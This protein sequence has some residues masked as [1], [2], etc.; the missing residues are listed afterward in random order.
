MNE[1]RGTM[2]SIFKQQG[3]KF[4]AWVLDQMARTL[5]TNR[6]AMGQ[7][8]IAALSLG[9]YVDALMLPLSTRAEAAVTR[10]RKLFLRSSFCCPHVRPQGCQ[11][12]RH[13]P[14]S[15]DGGDAR[16]RLSGRVAA[17]R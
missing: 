1:L 13:R 12:P 14:I 3:D 16:S 11:A 15:E 7:G 9:V 10:S 8:C 17:W 5:L 4:P 2:Q 6:V